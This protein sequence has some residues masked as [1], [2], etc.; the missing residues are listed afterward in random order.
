MQA[1]PAADVGCVPGLIGDHNRLR[2]QFQLADSDA[3]GRGVITGRGLFRRRCVVA[4]QVGKIVFVLALPRD[5]DIEIANSDSIQHPAGLPQAFH[6]QVNGRLAESH[7]A[8]ATGIAELRVADVKAECERIE[9]HPASLQFT[10]IG[11]LQVLVW[12]EI[13][14][15]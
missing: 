10:P 1:V 2:M 6:R 13:Q 7:K 14:R 5:L 9:Y 15:W 8:L 4:D 12:E 11:V 3:W